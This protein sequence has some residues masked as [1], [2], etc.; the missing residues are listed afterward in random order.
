LSIAPRPRANA[1]DSIALV[2]FRQSSN[3]G[4]D[5]ART[6]SAESR[7]ATDITRSAGA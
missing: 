2:L 3:V 5:A 7:S 4:Y 6:L 1:I